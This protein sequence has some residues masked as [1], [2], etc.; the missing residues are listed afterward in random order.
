MEYAGQVSTLAQPPS[1]PP[2]SCSPQCAAE[3]AT[4]LINCILETTQEVGEQHQTLEKCKSPTQ[5]IK[6]WIPF[7]EEELKPK[8]GLEFANL[9][10]CDKFYKSYA[11][12]VGFSIHN[13]KT[14]EGTHKYKYC[15]CSKQGF[16]RTSPNV[17]PNRK[18]KLTREDRP[19]QMEHEDK[20]ISRNWL[21]FLDYMRVTK[22][23]V[24]K[25]TT[26]SRGVHNELDGTTSARKMSELESFIG[27]NAPIQIGILPPKQ[28]K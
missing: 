14:K 3:F 24:K 4:L 13:K 25:L 26:S 19:L 15:V 22:R 7:C 16:R 5:I 27:S 23:D 6:E 10:E 8:E 9:D 12:Q 18:V 28:C 20:L 21:E 2:S 1:S 11:H 17:N